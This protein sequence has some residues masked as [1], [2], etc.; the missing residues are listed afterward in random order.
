MSN[1]GSRFAMHLQKLKVK[2]ILPQNKDG[3][4]HI[5]E[6]EG[7]TYLHGQVHFENPYESAHITTNHVLVDPGTSGYETH[8]E[9]TM[10]QTQFN[11]MVMGSLEQASDDSDLALMETE[12]D[13]LPLTGGL[14]HK[15][16]GIIHLDGD[17]KIDVI[18]GESGKL[19]YGGGERFKWGNNYVWLSKPI[20]MQDNAV[21]NVPIPEEDGDAA[22]KGYVDSKVGG[23]PVGSIMFWL[24]ETPPEG[25]LKLHGG[26]FDIEE[27]PELHKYLEATDGYTSGHLPNWA[28]R[29]PVEYGG[30]ATANLG[31]FIESQT[32]LPSDI[33]AETTSIPD[34]S[35]RTFAKSGGTN[36]YSDGLSKIA[37]KISGGDSVTR[38]PSVVGHYIIKHD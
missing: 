34:G 11:S 20:D 10:T 25:W 17:R 3:E 21:I 29:Y 4:I 37:V 12:R 18:W 32:K 1:W 36:A 7:N 15:V 33:K 30:H 22:N 5:N 38:P 14:E 8:E 6:D 9:G 35:M 16:T 23:V 2:E 28:G 27:N 13:Y 31:S 26:T 19:S 24:L